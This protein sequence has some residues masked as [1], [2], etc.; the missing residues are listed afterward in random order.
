HGDGRTVIGPAVTLAVQRDGSAFPYVPG[1]L[2]F[3]DGGLYRPVAPFFELWVILQGEEVTSAGQE[4]V[5]LTHRLLR[6]MGGSL[7][8]VAWVVSVANLKAAR[9][10]GDRACGFSAEVRLHANQYAARP[11]LAWSPRAPGGEPLVLAE[12]PIPLGHV[13]V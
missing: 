9:R 4:P 1:H 5:P 6:D 11:L 10:T 12:R 2:R 8:G 13:Q 3:K 7:E